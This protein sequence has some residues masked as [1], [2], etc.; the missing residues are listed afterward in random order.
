[1]K[2]SNLVFVFFLFH[3]M[4][5][6]AMNWNYPPAAATC[7]ISPW[8]VMGLSYSDG[9]QV[10]EEKE[11][12]ESNATEVASESSCEEDTLEDFE[13]EASVF[14]RG[15]SIITSSGI[16]VPILRLNGHD[17]ISS[18]I[19][20]GEAVRPSH[21]HQVH[22]PFFRGRD[23]NRRPFIAILFDVT[24]A[25]WMGDAYMHCLDDVC[26]GCYGYIER[27]ETERIVLF[28][29]QKFGD[30]V[31]WGITGNGR[32]FFTLNL[33]S[34]KNLAE[35]ICKGQL[36]I[37]DKYLLKLSTMSKKEGDEKKKEQ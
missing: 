16:D 7:T 27:E 15:I 11:K 29:E 17:S 34:T 5:S 25:E 33:H 19:Y 6:E 4:Y 23:R 20:S 14:E 18:G 35:L 22:T 31:I 10:T 26:L 13:E 30:R 3:S 8:E 12:S 24:W 36:T 32:D 28:V 2:Q 1:M 21:F 37:N 9:S